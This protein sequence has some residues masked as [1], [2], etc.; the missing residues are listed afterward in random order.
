MSDDHLTPLVIIAAI[1]V[2]VTAMR[3]PF[4]PPA[5]V[6]DLG[7]AE[8]QSYEE[9]DLPSSAAGSFRGLDL[10]RQTSARVLSIDE[11]QSILSFPILLPAVLPSAD[12]R[13]DT[14]EILQSNVDVLLLTFRDAH[15]DVLNSVRPEFT[16]VEAPWAGLAPARL[17][18]RFEETTINGHRAAIH[19]GS[20]SFFYQGN[21]SRELPFGLIYWEEGDL[22]L[23]VDSVNVRGS[24]LV[25]VA[26]SVQGELSTS[27]I[28]PE[29]VLSSSD[30]DANL[31]V[32][33]DN[34]FDTGVL[35]AR[36]GTDYQ[37]TFQNRGSTLHQW[38]I[39]GLPDQAGRDIGSRVLLPNQA[40]SVNF[41]IDQPGVY[42]FYCNIWPP[43]MRGRI[44]AE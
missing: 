25:Q 41:A 35:R 37:L 13:L 3:S 31:L 9:G 16:L 15:A 1:L 10:A 38:Q 20:R 2:V 19:A 28:E 6:I 4:A 44:I 24:D 7:H 21:E 12:F 42:E 33:R 5:A 36:V 34:M 26:E 18:L 23:S 27:R 30:P 43:D 32:G 8:V 40:E 14:I 39:R 11:A 22:L 17:P 29:L